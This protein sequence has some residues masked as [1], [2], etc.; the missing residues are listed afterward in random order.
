MYLHKK[1][2]QREQAVH[3]WWGTLLRQVLRLACME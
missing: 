3:W 1:N 2:G